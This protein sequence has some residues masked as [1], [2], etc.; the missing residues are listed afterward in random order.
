MWKKIDRV[1]GGFEGYLTG[2]LLLACT[3]VLFVN[4]VM[5]YFFHAASQW[6]E[7]AIRY[8]IVWVTFVGGS[9]CA[10]KGSHVGIDLFAQAIPPLGKKIVLA[11]GQFV[12]AIFMAMSTVFGWQMF[13][14]MVTTG[15]KSP[16]M[17]MPMSIV[18]FSMPLGFAL[19]TIQSVAAVVRVL[20]ANPND[21]NGPQSADDIDLSR[22]N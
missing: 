10:R 22:L 2:S 16:A 18:Y 14:L 9:I 17:L 5:R 21:D 11:A 8:A 7:E 20:R 1:L 13:Q 6:A 4:V 3:I 12:A 15:Q 19:T